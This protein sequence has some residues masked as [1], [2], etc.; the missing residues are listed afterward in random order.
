MLDFFFV[1]R[2]T[3]LSGIAALDDVESFEWRDAATV[4]GEEVAFA[5]NARALKD[6]SEKK[7]QGLFFKA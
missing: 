7:D 1:A 6:F 2:T 4:R 3:D 5:S